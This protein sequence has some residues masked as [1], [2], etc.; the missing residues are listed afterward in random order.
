ML[1]HGIHTPDGE[2]LSGFVSAA[3]LPF[4]LHH[5]IL[6]PSTLPSIFLPSINTPA[7]RPVLQFY[8][9]QVKAFVDSIEFLIRTPIDRLALRTTT[10]RHEQSRP[11]SS[12]S[13]TRKH[14]RLR[15]TTTQTAEPLNASDDRGG[16]QIGHHTK[17][18]VRDMI[19]HI[20]HMRIAERARWKYCSAL[21]DTGAVD[22]IHKQVICTHL[23]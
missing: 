15:S 11:P 2:S 1:L 22:I 19:A 17:L 16:T 20:I 10:S 18:A 9:W 8:H 14:S 21:P 7:E 5:R 23:S 12:R 6:S 13:D 4:R 3:R